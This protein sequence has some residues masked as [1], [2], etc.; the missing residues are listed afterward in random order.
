MSARA[1]RLAACDDDEYRE[2]SSRQI[3]EY[4]MQLARAGE[5]SPEESLATA[6]EGLAELSADRLRT[7]GHEFF[8]ARATHDDV[9]VGWA[10]LSPAPTFLGP[11]HERTCWLSQLTVEESQRRRGWARAILN[12]LERHAHNRGHHAI[13]LRVFDWNVIAR[14]VYQ[15]QGYCLAQKFE[16]DAHFCKRLTP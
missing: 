6:R 4:A 9:R 15:S 7:R 12:E 13:W 16:V 2:F 5:F 8:I 3:V 1:V 11:G 14:R 10:W